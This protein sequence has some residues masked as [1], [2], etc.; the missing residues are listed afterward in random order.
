MEDRSRAEALAAIDRAMGSGRKQGRE[1]PALR[2]PMKGLP[3]DIRE[4]LG[5]DRSIYSEATL[6]RVLTAYR[7]LSRYAEAG[8]IEYRF[9]RAKKSRHYSPKPFKRK[10]DQ[11]RKAYNDLRAFLGATVDS[12]D[13]L[14]RGSAYLRIDHPDE[15][16]K[17]LEDGIA[18]DDRPYL[19]EI[20]RAL[21]GKKKR[22]NRSAEERRP[23]LNEVALELKKPSRKKLRKNCEE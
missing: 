9:D 7:E 5:G 17:R 22:A 20:I 12:D 13:V 14:A 2:D 8:L 3:D 19:E 10:A 6:R 11:L 16:L 4:A 1:D 18:Y 15:I 23:G 21:T